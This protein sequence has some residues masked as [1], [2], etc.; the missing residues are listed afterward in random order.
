MKRILL[1]VA[2]VL[3]IG[4]VSAQPK[5]PADA[6]KAVDKAVAASQDAKKSTKPATWVNLAKAYLDAYEQPALNLLAGSPQVEVKL[7][8]KDQKVLETVAF[9]GTEGQFTVDKYADKD[10]Y[11]NPAG[12]LEFWIV[13]KQAV[14]GNLLANAA[15]ALAKAKELGAKEKDYSSIVE[16]IHTK[17]FT[18]A[19]N[20]YAIGD[21][22]KAEEYFK[23]AVSTYAAFGKID[24]MTIYY[25]GLVANMAGNHQSAIDAYKKCIDLKYY[26]EG[27]TFSNLADIY[28]TLGDKEACEKTLEDGFASYP[29]SQGILIGLINFYRENNEDPQKLFDLLHTAQVNE[30]NNASLYYV[31]GDVNKQLGN[32]DEAVKSYRKATEVDHNYVFGMLGEGMLFYDKAVE[33]Q[34]QA[35]N[36]MDD[37]K[38]AALMTEMEETLAKAIKPFEDCFGVSKD[39]DIKNAAAEYLKNIFFR[40]REKDESYPALFEKY[41]NFLK[42]E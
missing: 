16:T 1:A 33:I 3:S 4:A 18:D 28:K 34:D 10:L 38:Y 5:T 2:F 23:Q 35:N 29:Q 19:F 40:L 39:I 25:T 12:V 21:F 20:Q 32:I 7:V 37:N 13:T 8:T 6:K 22:A 15:D 9:E 31:E 14:E 41:N 26:Q 17:V 24:T 27:S 30:P 36:E 11:Y 42:G